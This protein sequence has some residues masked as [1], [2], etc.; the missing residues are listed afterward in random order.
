MELINIICILIGMILSAVG[1]IMIYDARKKTKKLFSFYDQNEGAKWFKIAG[2][3]LFILG[4]VVVF[5]NIKK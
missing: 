3:L 5:L 2:F 4:F 1:V